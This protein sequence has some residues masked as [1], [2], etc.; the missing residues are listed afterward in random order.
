M[1]SSSIP[2]SCQKCFDRRQEFGDNFWIHL[3]D[4]YPECMCEKVTVSKFSPY[5][6]GNSEILVSVV[7][8]KKYIASCGKIL[9]TLFDQRIRNGISTERKGL[10]TKSNFDLRAEKLV[11][12]RVNKSN[13]GSIE[14]SV[15]SIR[16]IKYDGKRAF[17]VYDTALKENKSHA[18]IASTT[19]PP[20]GTKERKKIRA[21]LR[22][23]LLGA[24][25][26]DCRVLSSAKIFEVAH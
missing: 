8:S 6:V 2:K 14:L 12:N 7:T 18:E 3:D 11:E 1:S 16:A 17:G 13:C 25:L 26:H 20:H 15:A 21:E 10:T 9:P 4:S 5:P 24:V 23:G 19:V 22:N